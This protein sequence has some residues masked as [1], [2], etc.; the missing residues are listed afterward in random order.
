[1]LDLQ[2]IAVGE[3]VAEVFV[4]PGW[5]VRTWQGNMS[6]TARR[7]QAQI[8]MRKYYLNMELGSFIGNG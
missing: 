8:G 2:T 6:P 7:T 5:V 1:M 3:T 4:P